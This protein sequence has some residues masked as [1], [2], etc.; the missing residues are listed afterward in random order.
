VFCEVPR[1]AWDDRATMNDKL[2]Y[3]RRCHPERSEGSQSLYVRPPK[4]GTPSH[5][6]T[7]QRFNDSTRRSAAQP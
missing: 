5:D 3:G 1:S 2:R 6:S 7:V 4:G